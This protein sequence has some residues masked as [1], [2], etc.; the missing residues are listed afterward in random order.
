MPDDLFPLAF[1]P[2]IA[3]NGTK[4]QSKGR[5][6]DSNLV[7]FTD[8][9]I[10][11]IGGWRTLQTA[12]GADLEAL[13]GIPRAVIA[14]RGESGAPFIAIGTTEKLYVVVAGELH[15]I[16][17]VGFVAGREDT[18]YNTDPG[19][20]GSGAYGA[21]AY[22]VGA[23][24]SEL[25]EADTWQFDT[26]GDYLAAVCTSDRKL[27]IWAGDTAVPAAVPT[28]APSSCVGVVVTPERFLVALGTDGNIRQ[29]AWPSQ[30]T[31]TDWVPSATNSAGDFPLTT[32]GR[33]LS[34]RRTKS[35]TLLWTDTDLQVMSY[36]GGTFLYRFSESGQ[37]CGAISP[38]AMATFDTMAAWMG[39]KNF[40]VYDGFVRPIPCDVRD[41][42]FSD[43]NDTQSVKV[44]AMTVAQYGEV[45]W[46]YC[47]AASTEVDRYV[48][49]NYREQH[50]T[51]GKMSRTAGCDADAIPHPVMTGPDGIVHEH[52]IFQD[53]PALV[54]EQ[55]GIL[56][57]SEEEDFLIAENGTDLTTEQVAPYL[58][59]GPIEIGDGDRLM[60]IQRLVPDEKTLGDVQAT[61]F[62]AFYPTS[63]EKESGPHTLE[64]PTSLREK[65]R[66]LRLRLEEVRATGWRVGV[67][68]LGLRPSSRR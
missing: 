24:T 32:P 3:R 57:V 15:D 13:V 46:F 59:S 19:A 30:E 48:V 65:G 55:D 62:T 60:E 45:W 17:P 37:K 41:Y 28:G 6:Y 2:G 51:I 33:I 40:Y 5:W 20:Y 21:G 31:T 43:F 12:A 64:N 4:Y 50:W 61:L 9:T 7:R 54:P 10:Q 29:L 25:L 49:Y 44:W 23:T 8:N 42:V 22:G 58:E 1:P 56:L 47:S 53:R 68:R 39:S 14:W 38:N 52:E 11:P 35:E 27:Y 18:G 63:E 26:F 66:Q 16:T 67:L 36:I 34:G